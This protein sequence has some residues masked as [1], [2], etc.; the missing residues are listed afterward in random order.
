MGAFALGCGHFGWRAA[1]AIN[2]AL[3]PDEPDGACALGCGRRGRRVAVAINLALHPD[4]AGWGRLRWAVGS[5][6]GY[7]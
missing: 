4:E 6:G 5:V 3:H 2:L 7:R 1:V